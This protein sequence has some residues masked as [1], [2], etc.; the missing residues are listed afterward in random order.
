MAWVPAKP[1]NDG[2]IINFPGQSRANFNAIGL[3]QDTALRITN[4]KVAAD[5]AIVDTKLAQ[6]ATAGKVNGTAIT[7][8]A[9]IPGGAGTIPLA[10]IPDTLTGK[11]ADLLDGQEGAYYRDADQV[12]SKHAADMYNYGIMNCF[13]NGAFGRTAGWEEYDYL[14]QTI[15]LSGS[16][17]SLAVYIWMNNPTP[18]IGDTENRYIRLKIGTAT[19]GTI[20]VPADT[21]AFTAYNTTIDVSAISGYQTVKLEINRPG[22]AGTFKMNGMSLIRPV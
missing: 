13:D 20:M 5:A 8:L 6:I 9:N 17:T 7:L 10:T 3:G 14:Q 11:D 1:A 22:A 21:D 16:E 4:A 18:G 2:L 15:Y 19:S 12:D